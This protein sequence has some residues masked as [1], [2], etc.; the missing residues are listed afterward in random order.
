MAENDVGAALVGPF[1][2]Y[3]SEWDKM[4]R[5]PVD[6]RRGDP[7]YEHLISLQSEK[8]DKATW[9]KWMNSLPEPGGLVGASG[10]YDAKM[11]TQDELLKYLMYNSSTGPEPP[12]QIPLP[13]PRPKGR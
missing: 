9:A 12:Q 2:K 10:F 6:D 11:P 4:R 5:A 8:D 3:Q 1:D 7:E 13:K